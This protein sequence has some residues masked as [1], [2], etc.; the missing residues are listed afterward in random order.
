MFLTLLE[1]CVYKGVINSQN[2]GFRQNDNGIDPPL[3][4]SDVFT[5]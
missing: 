5:K 1:S 4:M 2:T 3:S